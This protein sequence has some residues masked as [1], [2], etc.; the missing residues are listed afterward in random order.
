MPPV[1]FHD[2]HPRTPEVQREHGSE[3][4]DAQW[5]ALPRV[6][7]TS[8]PLKRGAARNE[9]VNQVMLPDGTIGDHLEMVRQA[10]REHDEE[11]IKRLDAFIAEHHDGVLR[12][13]LSR[14]DQFTLRDL[15]Y[16]A[17]HSQSDEL[18]DHITQ[19]RFLFIVD[20]NA[21]VR[22]YFQCVT[23]DNPDIEY[24]NDADDPTFAQRD[25]NRQQLAIARLERG[26]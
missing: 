20:A 2:T 23:A 18:E 14:E 16:W 6:K 3:Y 15:Q 19:N 4:T 22:I 21:V 11:D 10:T 8:P 1:K 25:A 5:R 12:G 26:G 24:E 9:F 7:H 13:N 17:N